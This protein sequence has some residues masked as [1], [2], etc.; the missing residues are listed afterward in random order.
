MLIKQDIDDG[1]KIIQKV[2]NILQDSIA[3]A[4]ETV[5]FYMLMLGLFSDTSTETDFIDSERN[6]LGGLIGLFAAVGD[7]RGRGNSGLPIM[8]FFAW[9]LQILAQASKKTQDSELA[10]ELFDACLHGFSNYKK[11]FKMQT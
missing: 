9:K 1:F 2:R 8:M 7:P 6:Y 3:V 10:E 5:S 4:P 11:Q